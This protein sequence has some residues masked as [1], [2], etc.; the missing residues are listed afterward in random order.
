V[1][2][3]VETEPFEPPIEMELI[4]LPVVEPRPKNATI[5]L[6]ALPA[7]KFPKSQDAALVAN[8]P[9]PI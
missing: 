3:G 6:P 7:V 8:S 1:V 9:V 5:I 2:F 4:V